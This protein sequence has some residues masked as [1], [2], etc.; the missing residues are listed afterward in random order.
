MNCELTGQMVHLLFSPEKVE[1]VVSKTNLYI[2][3]CLTTEQFSIL[4]QSILKGGGALAKGRWHNSGGS[5]VTSSLH[6]TSFN[7]HLQLAR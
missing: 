6:D 1:S 3:V 2:S 7:Q 5:L 4:T